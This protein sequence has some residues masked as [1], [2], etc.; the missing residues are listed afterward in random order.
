VAG[1]GTDPRGGQTFDVLKQA[2][3]YDKDGEYVRLWVPELKYVPAEHIHHP[4]TWDGDIEGYPRQPIIRRQEWQSDEAS[5]AKDR[6]M[7]IVSRMADG[8]KD[9]EII[10][11]L[12]SWHT[13]HN[14]A[15]PVL[16]V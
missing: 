2:I 14:I 13:D 8:M 4:W 5:E 12:P 15:K 11:W 10:R 7:K 16:Y 9:K 3:E 1:V 6:S